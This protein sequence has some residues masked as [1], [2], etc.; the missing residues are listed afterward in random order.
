MA[1]MVLARDQLYHWI[2]CRKCRTLT[3]QTV[4]PSQRQG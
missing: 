2:S 4:D 1:F 3:R